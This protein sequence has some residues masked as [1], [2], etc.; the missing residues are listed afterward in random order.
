MFQQVPCSSESCVYNR[1]WCHL[2]LAPWVPLNLHPNNDEGFWC[3]S[4][5]FRLH[6]ENISAPSLCA[7][8]TQC[9]VVDLA[10]SSILATKQHQTLFW[11]NIWKMTLKLALEGP[12]VVQVAGP[13][14]L[15]SLDCHCHFCWQPPAEQR[16][17]T[18]FCIGQYQYGR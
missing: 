15:K 17:S 13:C 3:P 11:F 6:Q 10:S 12:P 4:A 16:T 8:W 7:S 1:H 5:S 2:G 14:A 9:K 18:D